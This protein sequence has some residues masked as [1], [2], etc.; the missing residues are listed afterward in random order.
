[1][2]TKVIKRNKEVVEFDKN[3]IKEA[4]AKAFVQ[5]DGELTE[6]S[7]MKCNEIANYIYNLDDYIDVETIQDVVEN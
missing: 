4:I 6:Q 2:V 7:R 1:M 5:V 3:K